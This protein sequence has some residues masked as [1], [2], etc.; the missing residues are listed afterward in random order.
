MHVRDVVDAIIRSLGVQSGCQV[1]N[2]GFG[3]SYSV[4]EVV[5][6]VSTL[7]PGTSVEFAEVE[8]THE[9][10]DVVADHTL[11]YKQLGW[12]PQTDLKTGLAELAEVKN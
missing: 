7:F 3:T 11:I 12:R 2:V 4:R 8:R 1:F 10:S 6:M 5:E 9:V